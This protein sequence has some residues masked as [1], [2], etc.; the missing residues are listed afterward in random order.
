MDDMMLFDNL[1]SSSGAQN[2]NSSSYDD[3]YEDYEVD[4][5]TCILTN[6]FDYDNYEDHSIALN[7]TVINKTIFDL[8]YDDVND[9]DDGD[10]RDVT[11]SKQTTHDTNISSA[12]SVDSSNHNKNYNTEAISSS[13]GKSRKKNSA[14]SRTVTQNVASVPSTTPTITPKKKKTL[15]EKSLMPDHISLTD[16]P[17]K[18]PSSAINASPLTATKIVTRTAPRAITLF[19]KCSRKGCTSYGQKCTLKTIKNTFDILLF[20]SRDKLDNQKYDIAASIIKDLPDSD[21]VSL[22]TE[23][24]RQLNQHGLFRDD[25]LWLKFIDANYREIADDWHSRLVLPLLRMLSLENLDRIDLD[26]K[27]KRG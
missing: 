16:R 14:K 15:K 24:N 7:D 18:P 3:N 21:K 26:K 11:G 23:C 27:R 25:K 2:I 6:Y 17:Q 22:C 8:T 4:D 9:G 10:D 12:S 20:K 13:S 1:S 19:G 5:D